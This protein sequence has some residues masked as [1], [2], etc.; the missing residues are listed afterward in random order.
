MLRPESYEL[1][2]NTLGALTDLL[3]KYRQDNVPPFNRPIFKKLTEALKEGANQAIV[4]MNATSHTDDGTI[5]LAQAEDVEQYWNTTLEKR[6]SN[7]FMLAADYDA[8][9]NDPRL[10]TYSE[11]VVDFPA[12]RSNAI[13][14]A[15]LL[16][17]GI[18]AAAASDGY[19]GDGTISIQE[20]ANANPHNHD[21]YHFDLGADCDRRRCPLGEELR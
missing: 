16:K 21:A 10:Y 19:V 3:T 8:F 1:T 18:A 15:T 12:S 20:W 5:G 9:A 13:S 4:Y 6:F 14:G 2:T 17:T 11:T 7:A